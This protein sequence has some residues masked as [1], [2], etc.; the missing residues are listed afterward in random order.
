MA[1]LSFYFKQN[2]CKCA[3]FCYR[4]FCQVVFDRNFFP[5]HFLLHYVNKFKISIKF[6]V[7]LYLYRFFMPQNLWGSYKHFC[8]LLMRMRKKPS[9]FQHIEK[10]KNL[11]FPN[12]Y[13]SPSGCYWNTKK[14]I[15]CREKGAARF[16]FHNIFLVRLS[17]ESGA[18]EYEVIPLE[19][20]LTIQ[21]S[22]YLT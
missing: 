14:S 19:W 10:G 20:N 12:I 1:K 4:T 8:K 16:A 7:F 22:Y 11:F 18:Y 9:I 5:D 17:N 6:C 13:N 15:K 3:Y 2:V 21:F